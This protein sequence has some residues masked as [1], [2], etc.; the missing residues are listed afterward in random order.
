MLTVQTLQSEL[1]VRLG[2]PA[3]VVGPEILLRIEEIWQREKVQSGDKLFNGSLFSIHQSGPD[4]LV[5]WLAEYRCFVAQQ[6]DPSLRAALKI[7]PLAVT[8]VL[9]CKDGIVFGHRA[10][11]TEMDADLWELV[12]SGSVDSAAVDS[13]GQLN[14][15]R[16]LL[17]ELAEEI[18][19]HASEV[20][21]PPRV[22]ALVEDSCS[23][24]TD[25]GLTLTVDCSAIQILERFAALENR[26]YSALEVVAI[27]AIADF[28]HTCGTSLSEV[29]GALLDIVFRQR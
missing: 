5:G 4:A 27:D 8:G 20:S 21:I 16:C 10:S 19:I 9:Y 23:Q 6:R 25:V 12:P 18:G 3:P 24:V 28:R 7:R 29:S 2:A 11:E 15:E 1:K 17:A 22:I 13:D 26:E 14:L